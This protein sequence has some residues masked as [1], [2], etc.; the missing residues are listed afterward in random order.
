MDAPQGWRAALLQPANDVADADAL[1]GAREAH[2]ATASAHGLHRARADQRLGDLHQVVLGDPEDWKAA[3]DGAETVI[4]YVI[5][6]EMGRGGTA[7]P[8]EKWEVANSVF[9]FICCSVITIGETLISR[10][11]D[12]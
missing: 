3:I 7:S 9:P 5:Q 12:I 2:S 1:G 11:D 8:E 6:Q 4:E 10:M